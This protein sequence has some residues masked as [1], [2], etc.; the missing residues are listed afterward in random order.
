MEGW[1]AFVSGKPKFKV[2]QEFAYT[3]VHSHLKNP[4]IM[5]QLLSRLS[6]KSLAK[7]MFFRHAAY[8]SHQ[9]NRLV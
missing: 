8:G 3:P 1:Q 6:L 9:S 7:L 5:K 2:F 4:S